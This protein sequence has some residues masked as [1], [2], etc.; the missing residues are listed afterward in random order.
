[1]G[2][3]SPSVSTPSWTMSCQWEL[4]RLSVSEGVG[5]KPVGASRGK[6]DVRMKLL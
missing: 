5:G 1:M 2:E 3:T 4:T 6:K